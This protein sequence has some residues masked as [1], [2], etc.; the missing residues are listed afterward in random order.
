[1]KRRNKAREC[2]SLISR[3]TH[4]GSKHQNFADQARNFIEA[5]KRVKS[6]VLM[7]LDNTHRMKWNSSAK[8]LVRLSS[9]SK[10]INNWAKHISACFF[11][12]LQVIGK[13]SS[14]TRFNQSVES[15]HACRVSWE[16]CPAAAAC[17]RNND[18]CYNHLKEV[19]EWSINDPETSQEPCRSN[20][21]INQW[22]SF[23]VVAQRSSCWLENSFNMPKPSKLM[24]KSASLILQESFKNKIG[25]KIYSF[26]AF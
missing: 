9:Q 20:W 3:A 15:Y 19:V 21:K 13:S 23:E 16:Q 5:S 18:R 26:R 17:C 1:V 8:H 2:A 11:Q 4:Q 12:I 25:L 10:S 6:L 22:I 14:Q 7:A 24:M